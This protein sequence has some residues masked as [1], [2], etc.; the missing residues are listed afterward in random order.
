MVTITAPEPFTGLGVG[1]VEFVDGVATTD[2]H[3]VISYCRDL[4]Y[5]VTDEKAKPAVKRAAAKK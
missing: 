1:G 5:K 2:N 3:A 4:G